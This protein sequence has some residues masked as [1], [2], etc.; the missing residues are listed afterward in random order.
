MSKHK[1]R[2]KQTSQ[3]HHRHD[4]YIMPLP[5]PKYAIDGE[6]WMA[7]CFGVV[8]GGGFIGYII[9]LVVTL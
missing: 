1:K 3:Y 8:F 9:Y 4:R 5:E 2:R 6:Q 7:W